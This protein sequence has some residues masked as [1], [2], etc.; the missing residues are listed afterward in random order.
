MDSGGGGAGGF[1]ADDEVGDARE[2][3]IEDFGEDANVSIE[4]DKKS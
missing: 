3:F 2:A 1:V 4:R